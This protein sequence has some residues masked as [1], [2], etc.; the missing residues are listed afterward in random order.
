MSKNNYIIYLFSFLSVFGV[1]KAN[2][3]VTTGT[4]TIGSGGTYAT[5]A[6]AVSDLSS[7]TITG[8]V[9][10]NILSG[11]YS[12]T[13]AVISSITGAS[14]TNTVTFQSAT[15]NAADVTIS[16]AGSS[17]SNNYIFKLDGAEYVNIRNMTLNNTGSTYGTSIWFTNSASNDS[18][19]GCIMKGSN[20]SSSSNYKSRIYANP[21]TGTANVIQNN[22]FDHGSYGMYWYGSSTSSLNS[23]TVIENNT[24]TNNYYAAIYSYYAGATHFNNNTI[25]TSGVS[26]FYTIYFYFPQEGLEIKNNTATVS[27]SSTV[28]GMYIYYGNYYSASPAATPITVQN[29]TINISNGT[30]T[31]YVG[32]F[33]RDY[34]MDLSNNTFNT[35]NTSGTVYAPYYLLGYGDHSKAEHNVFNTTNTSGYVYSP[36]YGVYSANYCEANDNKFKV[37]K[38]SNYAYCP[39]YGM[40]SSTGSKMQRDTFDVTNTNGYVY[41]YYTNAQSATDTSLDNYFHSSAYSINNYAAFYHMG[42]TRGNTYDL[43]VTYGSIYNYFY[44][45][46]GGT[47][48]GNTIHAQ[49]TSGTINGMYMYMPTTSYNGANIIGNKFDFESNTGTVYGLYA[50]YFRGDKLMSNSISIKTSGNSYLFYCSNGM[51]GDGYMFNNTF[52]SN[53]SGS[54]NYLMW[55][56]KS[57]Y[58]GNLYSYNNIFSASNPASS[59]VYIK[60][61][62]IYHSDYNLFYNGGSPISIQCNTPSVTA[63]NL[64]DWRSATNRDI[65]SLNYAPAY[66]DAANG[67]LT[68]DGTN[69]NSWS[70]HGR[71]I[72]LVGDT[73][74]FNG[75]VRPRTPDQGVPDLGAYEF[76]PSVLPPDAV[77]VPATPSPSSTQVFTFGED[78]VGTIEWGSGAPSSVSVKQYTGIRPMSG[79]P[80]NVGRMYFYTAVNTSFGLFDYNPTIRYKD[81]WIG[82][83]S[84]EVN[85]RIARQN[86]SS[87]WEGFNYTN[88]ITDTLA[89]TLR[90]LHNFDTLP[91]KFTGVENARIGIRCV[92]PPSGLTHSDVAADS[93]NESWNAEFNPVGY[94]VIVDNSMSDP[95]Q[96]Y[97][98]VQFSAGNNLQL[99]N[100]VEDTKYYIHVR[101]ICGARDTSG[102]SIDSFTTLITCHAPTLKASNITS[103]HAVISWD[104]VK[105]AYEYEYAFDQN[106]SDPTFGTRIHTSSMLLTSLSPNTTYYFHVSTLCNSVYPHSLTWSTIQFTTPWPAGIDDP[107]ADVMTAYP[108]PTKDVVNILLA[109]KYVKEATLQLTDLRGRVVRTQNV[110]NTH[111]TVNLAG[112]PAGV[113]T[114]RYTS[115]DRTAIIKVTKQ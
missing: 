39:Y 78:T 14:S 99:K 48:T 95:T 60:D 109:D 110:I 61:A 64:G 59:S 67:D 72:H 97:N 8:P 50:A 76:T 25:T 26:S 5:L 87:P 28:Y 42:Y 74:D 82:D 53:S 3:T 92:I 106:P 88:G 62:S 22:T 29:N 89:N 112:L 84:S 58:N 51:Y 100:L 32:Y 4:Y 91:S 63:T 103:S 68:P 105:T 57:Y 34:S 94:Q 43:N 35:T 23:G 73:L 102:W 47:W 17:S 80:S 46:N 7:S 52:H 6:D 85:A 1:L 86:G 24:F 38:S 101:T 115:A 98:N 36:F 77:A 83:V 81:P 37:Q 40:Y 113:Y 69:P 90:P 54:T 65:N 55:F 27:A 44:Y 108:N 70:M 2:A 104:T 45:G 15:G 16:F 11:T 75:N 30:G 9:V 71:G 56:D 107:A 12:S 49:S 10:F 96:P 66:T 21:N 114:L 18:I 20:T 79:I 33:Y 93:A 31:A 111:T 41:H 13:H 19:T